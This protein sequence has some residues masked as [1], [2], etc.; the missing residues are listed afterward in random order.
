[1]PESRRAPA[2]GSSPLEL[3]IPWVSLRSG[4]WSGRIHALPGDLDGYPRDAIN[5]LDVLEVDLFHLL[6][7]R[8]ANQNEEVAAASGSGTSRASVG[9]T[10]VLAGTRET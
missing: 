10:V 1:M 4:I 7:M 5:N 9:S 2:L 8:C 3:P 6:R